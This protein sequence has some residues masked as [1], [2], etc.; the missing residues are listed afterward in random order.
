MPL[1]DE[2]VKHC[3]DYLDSALDAGRT[4]DDSLFAHLETEIEQFHFQQL[5]EKRARLDDLRSA[6]VSAVKTL[7]SLLQ[8][9]AESNQNDALPNKPAPKVKRV[10]FG[11]ANDKGER[12]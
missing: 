8:E 3:T 12:S 2:L 7:F 5:E 9:Q 6:V 1:N 4:I 10:F 11:L